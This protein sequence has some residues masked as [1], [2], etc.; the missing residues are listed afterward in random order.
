MT[1]DL[2]EDNGHRP[3]T[4]PPALVDEAPQEFSFVAYDV[5]DDGRIAVITLNRPRQRNAQNRGML[6]ELGEAFERAEATSPRNPSTERAGGPH[7]L[8]PVEGP[9]V[10]GSRDAPVDRQALGDD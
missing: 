3:S 1:G 10:G 9:F 6:V 8:E 5:V 7:A 4:A 2:C